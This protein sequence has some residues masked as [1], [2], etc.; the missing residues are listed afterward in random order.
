[1]ADL[2]VGDRVRVLV[3]TPQGEPVD[4][5]V[6]VVQDVIGKGVGVELDN[7]V[8]TGHSLDGE[9]TDK[10]K[11]DP[12]TGVTYGKGWWVLS[13]NVEVLSTEE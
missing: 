1:M 13:D 4:G 2:K 6:A 3:A 8:A 11:T 12:E 5:T 7:Y 10:E 9:L